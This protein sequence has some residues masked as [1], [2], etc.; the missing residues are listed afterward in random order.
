MVLPVS[1]SSGFDEDRMWERNLYDPLKR[2]FK[3]ITLVS[4]YGLFSQINL[5]KISKKN[6]IKTADKKILSIFKK[7]DSLKKY[8][9]F[10]SYLHSENISNNLI[11]QLPKNI[12]KI[13]YTTNFHQFNLYKPLLSLY[14]VNIY[15]SSDAKKSYEKESKNSYYMPFA[16][17]ASNYIPSSNKRLEHYSFVGTSYGQ[18]SMYCWRVLQNNIPF[19][20]YGANWLIGS[21]KKYLR[22]LQVLKDSY[23]SNSID[24]TYKLLHEKIM[25]ELYNK[26]PGHIHS[27]LSDQNYVNVLHNSYG[28]INLPESRYDHSFENPNVLL[29]ANLRDF[30]V[31]MSSGLLFTQRNKE[32]LEFYEE[33][34]E[35]ILFSNELELI[36]KLLFYQKNP[37]LRLKISHASYQ[38]A[39]SSHTWDNRFKLFFNYIDKEVF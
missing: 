17:E 16:A 3:D 39:I 26:H 12:L 18:R 22:P 31:P 28:I 8:D 37:K 14:D 13:N 33:D 38:R 5:K 7:N 6:K 10:F 30:E 4:Y 27:A 35:V 20:I 23:F 29:G 32:I 34:K 11:E 19:E 21:Y 9:I 15:A 2:M 24:S 36:D 1:A 25:L